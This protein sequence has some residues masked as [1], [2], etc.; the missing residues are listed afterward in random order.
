MRKGRLGED[1]DIEFYDEE[2]NEIG[3]AQKQEQERAREIAV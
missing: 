1:G 2:N 3:Q